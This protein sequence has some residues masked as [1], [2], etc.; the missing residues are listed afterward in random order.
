MSREATRFYINLTISTTQ[1]LDEIEK[2]LD[3]ELP[4]I[5]K[6]IPELVR[7]PFYFGIGEIGYHRIKICICAE[8]P[9]LA[10]GRIK[11]ELMHYL[12]DAFKNNGFQL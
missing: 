1:P 12:Y 10:M 4:K 6:Q 8:C 5:G 3:R 7:G 11:S 2:M 9:Q